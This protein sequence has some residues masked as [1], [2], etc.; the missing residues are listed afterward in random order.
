MPSTLPNP[1]NSALIFNRISLENILGSQE[2]SGISDAD[3]SSL[4]EVRRS[5]QAN[6]R[7]PLPS[8]TKYQSDEEVA[9]VRSTRT[10]FPARTWSPRSRLLRAT[11]E[12][13]PHEIVR[14]GSRNG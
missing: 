13:S 14:E 4:E 11:R 1:R 5:R 6:L 7:M 2:A 3:A 8:R 12:V 10:S 9:A